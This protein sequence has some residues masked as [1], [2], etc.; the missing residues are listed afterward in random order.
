MPHNATFAFSGISVITTT[1]AT[2]DD[3]QRLARGAVQQRLAAC[4]QVE[5]ITSH[6]VW[7]GKLEET[8]EWRLTFK[9]VPDGVQPLLQWLRAEHPYEVPQLLMRGEQA[10]RDYALWVAQQVDVPVE[11]RYRV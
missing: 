4:G 6:Y 3:A 8:P 10:Q 5:A 7:E 9:T 1:V 11:K 2:Q